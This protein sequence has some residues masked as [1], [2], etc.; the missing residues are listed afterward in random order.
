MTSLALPKNYVAEVRMPSSFYTTEQ[1]RN[2]LPNPEAFEI[3]RGY[4]K[5]DPMKDP[6][7]EGGYAELTFVIEFPEANLRQAEDK[8]L[9]V[10]NQIA[11]IMSAYGGSPITTPSLFRIATVT[12]GGTIDRQ[13][14]YVYRNSPYLHLKFNNEV[15]TQLDYYLKQASLMAH[16]TQYRLRSAI[17]WYGTSIGAPHPTV[18]YVAAWTGLETIEPL[19]NKKF[20]PINLKITCH[21]C[22][23]EAGVKRNRKIAAIKHLSELLT[24]HLSNSMPKDTRNKIVND[25]KLGLSPEAAQRLRNDTVHVRWTPLLR[26]HEG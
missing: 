7:D 17:Y 14:N 18:S 26:Q 5:L 23:N 11:T 12:Q 1:V 9:N 6:Y 3:L 8:A 4:W 13:H 2:P 21:I 19:I 22:N 20:H 24:N 16:Q 25:L 15:K 10:A